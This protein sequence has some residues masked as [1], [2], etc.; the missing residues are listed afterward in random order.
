MAFSSKLAPTV[1]GSQKPGRSPS[2]TKTAPKRR[3]GVAAAAGWKTGTIASRNGKA[4]VA[5]IP[6][7]IVRRDSALFA[8]NMTHSLYEP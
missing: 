5:P 3:T 6:R 4:R 8:M 7:R 1:V 2:G